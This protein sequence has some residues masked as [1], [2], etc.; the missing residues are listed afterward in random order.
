MIFVI[1]RLLEPFNL[2]RNVIELLFFIIR[3]CLVLILFAFCVFNF[4]ENPGN[5]GVNL[6]K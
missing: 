4:I 1:F 6:E 3:N 5:M 2:E